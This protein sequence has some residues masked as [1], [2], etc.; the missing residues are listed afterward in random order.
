MKKYL[1]SIILLLI[2]IIGVAIGLYI[3]QNN[4]YQIID[5]S[6]GRVFLID[7]KTGLT[8]RNVA[9]KDGDTP[10]YWE[11]TKIII[12]DENTHLPIG[13]I[14][15]SEKIKQQIKSEQNKQK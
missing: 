8:W 4:R 9:I 6:F 15:G 14:K 10:G 5:C 2:L 1:F 3:S 12:E 13:K 7:T 11:E